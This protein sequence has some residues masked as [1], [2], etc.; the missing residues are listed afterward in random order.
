MTHLSDTA[1]GNGK[2]HYSALEFHPFLEADGGEVQ[3]QLRQV[4]PEVEET[5]ERTCRQWNASVRECLRN[6][7]GLRLTSAGESQAVPVKIDG[8]MP[9][10]FAKVMR[11]FAGLEW[12]LMRRASLVQLASG[13]TFLEKNLEQ[14]RSLWPGEAGPADAA[15]A[16]RVR[17]T[18][19][20]WL[21]K[22]D[23][24]KAVE[25]IV[26]IEEDS[27]GAYHFRIP[28]IR[29]YWVVIGVTAQALGVSAQA[30]TVVVLAHELAHAYSHLG[31]DIDRRSWDTEAFA[32]TELG[33]VEGLAQFY[34]RTVCK[35]LETR[36][37]AALE[38]FE[39]LL[40]H[41]SGAYRA[42]ERWPTGSG[43]VGEVLR[44]SMIECR[45]KSVTASQEFEEVIVKHRDGTLGPRN[46]A[47]LDD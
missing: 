12:L 46:K 23:E 17:E 31:R 19:E 14:A 43:R 7:M 4:A 9:P 8:G 2:R 45:T 42:H 3:R 33:I 47:L 25:R 32:R 20:A 44:A 37:P 40:K 30:L 28:E 29:I 39:T 16:R 27:L 34:A 21:R 18:A 35:R 24:L 22:L 36:M 5:V 13:A 26:G 38:A 11:E 10:L 15:D 41:Q 1:W 6:E